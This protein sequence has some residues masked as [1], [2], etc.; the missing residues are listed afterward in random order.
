MNKFNRLAW[1]IWFYTGINIGISIDSV[2]LNR[3]CK[4]LTAIKWFQVFYF[5]IVI[6]CQDDTDCQYRL[7]D[8]CEVIVKNGRNA[9]WAMVISMTSSYALVPTI[10]IISRNYR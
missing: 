8:F 1:Y 9:N 3:I 5:L 4:Y 7:C 2:F 6:S 10:T